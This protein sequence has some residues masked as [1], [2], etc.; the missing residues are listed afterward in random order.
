L[1]SDERRLRVLAAAVRLF[2]R[3]G[4]EGASMDDIAAAAGITKPVLYDHFKSKHA[5]FEAVLETVRGEL[6]SRGFSHLSQP[7][8]IE[9]GLRASIHAFFSYAVEKPDAMRV[10]LQVPKTNRV[11]AAISKNI[12]SGASASIASMM[13]ANWPKAERWRLLAAT[14]FI[15]GGLRALADWAIDETTPSVEQLVRVVMSLIWSGL[16]SS[17]RPRRTRKPKR[18]A[19]VQRSLDK[20]SANSS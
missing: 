12:Q 16:A 14:E 11:A 4:Y 15:R 13:Q 19:T 10:L 1:S 20:R 5:M 2:A 17:E 18:V 3:N 7:L 8:S 9:E 6:L